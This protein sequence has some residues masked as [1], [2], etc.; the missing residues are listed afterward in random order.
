MKEIVKI[1]NLKRLRISSIEI[2]EID[3]EIL[4]LIKE[5]KVI[6]NHLHIPLQSGCNKILKAMNRKYDV[7][8]YNDVINKIRAIRPNIAIT[9][10]VIVGF[11]GETDEDFNDII[12]Y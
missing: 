3:D 12:I 11:P 9:T 6:V 7:E 1:K 2:T 5:H 4:N 8:Y 10:D